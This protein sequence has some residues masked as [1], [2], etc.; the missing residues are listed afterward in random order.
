MM[1][2]EERMGRADW[3]ELAERVAAAQEGEINSI[4]R[5]VVGA[6]HA[7]RE[8]LWARCLAA[9]G[10]GKATIEDISPV[11]RK[12]CE[13]AHKGRAPV[14]AR[15]AAC[16]AESRRN[17]DGIF[18]NA[19]PLA[20]LAETFAKERKGEPLNVEEF[21]DYCSAQINPK[22]VSRNTARKVL[23]DLGLPRRG[24]G[25]PRIMFKK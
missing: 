16:V 22:F 6:K 3:R 7:T 19:N 23:D 11:L 24:R 1:P 18:E 4:L 15:V 25:R 21:R 17:V 8:Y 12:I 9:V 5:R 20:V 2:H 13:A 10:A 14:L